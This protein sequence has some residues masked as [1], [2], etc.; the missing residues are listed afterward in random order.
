MRGSV[1]LWVR[2]FFDKRNGLLRTDLLGF[3]NYQQ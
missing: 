2:Y 3:D 1:S